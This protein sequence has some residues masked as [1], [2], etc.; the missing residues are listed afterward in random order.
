MRHLGV[1]SV[2]QWDPFLWD[3]WGSVGL[4]SVGHLGVQ[5]VVV[6]RKKKKEKEFYKSKPAG[7]NIFYKSKLAGINIFY[8]S[9]LA[10]INNILFI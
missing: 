4:H 5:F 7:I 10:G 6:T 1:Y 2:G 3:I 8:K 9:K